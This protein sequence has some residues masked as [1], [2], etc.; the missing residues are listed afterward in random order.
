MIVAAISAKVP[1]TAL[2]E[3]SHG[4]AATAA[5]YSPPD[6][7]A[8]LSRGRGVGDDDMDT[9]FGGSVRAL[10]G[11]AGVQGERALPP[12]KEVRG[13]GAAP[14]AA[15]S[16]PACQTITATT[17]RPSAPG[18]WAAGSDSQ[19]GMLLAAD[20]GMGHA[21][22]GDWLLAS[23]VA[24]AAAAVHDGEDGGG[25]GD[26]G[27]SSD[28]SDDSDDSEGSSN[29][30]AIDDGRNSVGAGEA[31]TAGGEDEF[32][33]ELLEAER[34]LLLAAHTP[35]ADA[36]ADRPAAASAAVV[37]AA[38]VAH[39]A[40]A[41]AAADAA[42]AAARPSTVA[43]QA[44]RDAR[45]DRTAPPLVASD[46]AAGSA[47]GC[48][49]PLAHVLNTALLQPITALRRRTDEALVRLFMTE[50]GLEEHM[51]SL[52]AFLLFEQARARARLPCSC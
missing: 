22:V 11:G 43:N 14:A 32:L 19:H 4:A 49:V 31:S 17:S 46:A 18:M 51:R 37:A 29:G 34:A 27:S 21:D 42:A 36:G 5:D 8:V 48:H 9:F 33:R 20:R 2:E 15:C 45:T 10:L 3:G 39:A 38:D 23:G 47:R 25:G 30:S 35:P 13:P 6:L 50:L 40:A 52:R 41:A 26:G 28:D 16:L 24:T 12:Q 44:G 1:A 7:M